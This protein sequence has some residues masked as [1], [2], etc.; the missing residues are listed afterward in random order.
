MFDQGGRGELKRSG[1]TKRRR[2]LLGH[3]I[4]KG[5]SR[6][7][8]SE[9]HTAAIVQISD[10]LDELQ[11]AQAIESPRD[12][13]LSNFQLHCKAAHGLWHRAETYK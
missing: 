9:K 3:P 2:E 11:S 12:N 7:R 4:E 6:F 8:C 5:P 13:R 10:T 1:T